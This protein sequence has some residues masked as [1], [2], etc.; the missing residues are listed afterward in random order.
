MRKNDDAQKY[1]FKRRRYGWGW[2]PVTWQGLATVM[3][4]LAIVFVAALQLPVKPEQ[5]TAEELLRFFALTGFALIGLATI[6]YAK[7]PRPHWR[8]GKKPTDDPDEDF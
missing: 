3:L 1:W 8:W 5:P 7:G 4:A 2:V 6:S